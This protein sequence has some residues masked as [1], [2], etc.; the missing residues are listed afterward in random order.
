MVIRKCP[1]LHCKASEAN[2]KVRD[3]LL[4]IKTKVGETLEGYEIFQ[5]RGKF[6]FPVKRPDLPMLES[7][8]TVTLVCF[9]LKDLSQPLHGADTSSHTCDDQFLFRI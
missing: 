4:D 2:V 5:P 6:Q 7:T 1:T 8:S 9:F 3:G